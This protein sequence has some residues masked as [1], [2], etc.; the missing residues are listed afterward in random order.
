MP[1][2]L[3]L[4]N[5]EIANYLNSKIDIVQHLLKFEQNMAHT[6]E[7]IMW[8][9]TSIDKK[10]LTNLDIE[11]KKKYRDKIRR[12][13]NKDLRTWFDLMKLNVE[14]IYLMEWLPTLVVEGYPPT[15]LHMNQN[16]DAMNMI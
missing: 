8:A 5:K 3:L 7:T 15:L 9:R 10:G 11:A 4:N 16:I 6:A 2:K 12:S 13:V 14:S 1:I